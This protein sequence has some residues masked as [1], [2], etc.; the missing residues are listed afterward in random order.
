MPDFHPDHVD[1]D[2]L[3]DETYA[4][5]D[6]NDRELRRRSVLP[7]QRRRRITTRRS[8]AE[9]ASAQGGPMPANCKS[10]NGPIEWATMPTGK[11]M[12]IDATPVHDGNVAA[13]RDERGDLVAR[14]LKD[15]DE[16]LEGERRG[17]SHFATCPNAAAHRRPR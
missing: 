9:R 10:C 5:L 8:T 1:D 3:D 15:D 11:L 17:T 7:A 14:V 13:R 12:P 16:L 4:L 2:H 6:A